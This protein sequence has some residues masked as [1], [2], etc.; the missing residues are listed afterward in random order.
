[1]HDVDG[2]IRLLCRS[3]AE[4]IIDWIGSIGLLPL[5]RVLGGVGVDAIAAHSVAYDGVEDSTLDRRP[6]HQKA[7][8]SIEHQ[9]CCNW[10]LV[11]VA[12]SSY[13]EFRSTIIAIIL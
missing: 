9:I 2:A 6:K 12:V 8:K 10:L 7:Q 3:V 11:V 13:F 1:M 4:E 5:V